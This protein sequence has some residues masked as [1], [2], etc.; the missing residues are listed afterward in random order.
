MSA[1]RRF[2]NNIAAANLTRLARP[3][4]CLHVSSKSLKA[5]RA[6]SSL[7][8]KRSNADDQNKAKNTMC[9]INAT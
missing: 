9:Y 5:R 4:S 6:K 3:R 1:G 7:K 8:I 2:F